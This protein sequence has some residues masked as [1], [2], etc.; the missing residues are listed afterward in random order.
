MR[1]AY[2]RA[3]RILALAGG[4]L[5]AGL[6]H[7]G[8]VSLVGVFPGK[9]AVIAIDG[10]NPK[11]VKIGQTWS[12]VTVREV[13][14]TRAV[15]EFDGKRHALNL[16]QHY[17]SAG[18]KGTGDRQRVTLAADPRGH[19]VVDGSVN[20]GAMRFLVDT[21]ATLIA[22][23]ARDATRLGVDYRKGQ[24]GVTQTANGRTMGWRVKLDRVR[25]GE[26]ELSGVDAVVLEGGLEIALLGMSFL[27][28]LEMKR[29]GQTMVLVRRF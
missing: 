22:L 1:G 24:P 27:N 9:A 18:S 5:A 15:I 29:D 10:G 6:A 26:I 3:G 17:R 7:A 25:I 4:L 8:D 2:C 16:G 28:R 23:P 12:G 13:E 21:G 11:T 14:R 20:G 19:F